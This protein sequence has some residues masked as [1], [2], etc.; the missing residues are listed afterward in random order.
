MISLAKHDRCDI[1]D[2]NDLYWYATGARWVCADCWSNLDME[3]GDADGEGAHDPER[4]ETLAAYLARTAAP[5][6]PPPAAPKRA[7]DTAAMDACKDAAMA[8]LSALIQE[9]RP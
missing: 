7:P 9:H 3:G 2:A 1:C 6:A 8:S 4:G 5:V